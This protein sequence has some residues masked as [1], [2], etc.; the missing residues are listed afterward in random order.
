MDR[1]AMFS[2][3][4]SLLVVMTTGC[5]SRTSKNKITA[6]QSRN[7]TL[8]DQLNRGYSDL[9]SAMRERD[10]F[11]M[12]LSNALTEINGLRDQLATRVEPEPAPP[13]WT[14][15]PG[16]AMI[17]IEGSVLFSAGKVTL[18]NEARRTLDGIVRIIEGEYVDK[19]ILVFGHTDNRPIKKSGWADN[20]QLSSERALAV[21]RFL[22]ERGVQPSRLVAAGCGEH[23]SRVPNS[24]EPN[25][26]AN[27]RV[28]IFAID[29]QAGTGRAP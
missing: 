25:R 15:V 26:T 1:R 14:A 29:A 13:G 2:I 12:R 10:D 18:R 17:A 22:R 3:T 11:N 4:L 7:A 27:R 21:V 20:W 8:T 24:S 5:A 23:R 28:E 6:L 19:D 16:G 9:E